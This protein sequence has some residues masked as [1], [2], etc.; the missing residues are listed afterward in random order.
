MT[1]RVLIVGYGSIG[2]RHLR[3]VRESSPQSDVRVLRRELGATAEGADGCFSSLDDALAFAPQVAIIANPAPFHVQIALTLARQGCHLLVEKPLS[4]K[5]EG[6]SELLA[7]AEDC[8]VVLQVAY[9]L[10]FSPSLRDFRQLVRSGRIGRILSIR[11]ET[12]QHLETWRP[13]TDYRLGVS[14]KRE[15]GGGVLLELSHEL[16]Y[17]RWIFGDIDW[18]GAWMSRQSALKINVEDTAH[19]LL[20]VRNNRAAVNACGPVVSLSLDFL[21]RD[22]TRRCVAIGEVGSLAWDGIAGSV[23]LFGGGGGAESEVLS[24]HPPVR[25]E[26]YREQWRHFLSC[27]ENK[28]SPLVGG[29]DGLAVLELVKTAWQ[30]MELEGARV[31]LNQKER[32]V[33]NRE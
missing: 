31:R 11:C 17:L 16:D 12:G 29:R 2:R 3:I 27:I 1:Q 4:D 30:S 21:R 8:G 19:L 25:D 13:G 14:A 5:P 32:M 23:K 26:T 7:A 10:R 24:E 28:S 9:N 20:G 6:V 22:T 15:F 18:V 33:T